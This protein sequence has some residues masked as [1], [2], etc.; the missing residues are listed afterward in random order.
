[1]Q[2]GTNNDGTNTV[3]QKKCKLDPLEARHHLHYPPNLHQQAPMSRACL[4]AENNR[5][6]KCMTEWCPQDHKQP[7]GHPKRHWEDD[8]DEA[9]DPNWSHVAKD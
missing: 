2:D 1:M 8:L 9:I 4:M 6:N 3:L 5:W 7:R